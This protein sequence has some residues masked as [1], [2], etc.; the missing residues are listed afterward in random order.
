MHQAV[1]QIMEELY[2]VEQAVRSLPEKR[3]LSEAFVWHIPT[4]STDQLA[5]LPLML[6]DSLKESDIDEPTEEMLEYLAPVVGSLQALYAN[7]IPGL[8]NGNATHAVGAYVGTM[9]YCEFIIRSI[10][11]WGPP[12]PNML[13]NQLLRRLN[14]IDRDI[15]GIAPTTDELK[16][17]LAQI[18]AAHE[19]AVELPG[20]LQELRSA[21][22]EL[23]NAAAS[24]S[25]ALGRI[26][27][28][29]E[30]A[31]ANLSHIEEVNDSSNKLLAQ[32]NEAHRITTSIGLAAAFDDRARRLNFSLYIWVGGLALALVVAMIVGYFRLSI[33][34]EVLAETP[35]SPT[36]VWVQFI[37]S[38]LSIGAPVWFAWMATKQ[39]SQRFK[40]S[41][42]YAYKASIAKAYEGFRRQAVRIDPEFEKVLFASALVRLDEAPLRLMEGAIHGSPLHEAA[43]NEAVKSVLA[44]IRD[45]ISARKTINKPDAPD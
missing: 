19:A 27:T 6:A 25:N 10:S 7:I 32:V 4:L 22:A 18:L 44:G 42:D 21:Q 37:L 36:K 33:M 1:K 20:T 24:A 13:P 15:T 5:D 35:L 12:D 11:S 17:K 9:S 8:A 28:I 38:A 26:S 34:R 2:R 43:G 3:R 16:A 23:R 14:K 31:F 29:E 41:E 30:K 40:L 39:V 45:R